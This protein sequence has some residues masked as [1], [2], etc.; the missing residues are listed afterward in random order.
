MGHRRRPILP[1]HLAQ[2]LILPL[3][4]DLLLGALS[5]NY[6]LD[7]GGCLDWTTRLAEPAGKRKGPHSAD[8]NAGCVWAGLSNRY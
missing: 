3:G 8:D 2:L 5:A 1:V 6:R 7:A 4:D